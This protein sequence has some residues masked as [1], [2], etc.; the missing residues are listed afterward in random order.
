MFETFKTCAKNVSHQM[1]NKRQNVMS[2]STYEV[3]ILEVLQA[4][5]KSGS[6]S[7]GIE[8]DFDMNCCEPGLSLMK[9]LRTTQK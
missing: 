1:G 3:A 4:S 7:H 6:H 5:L 9:R 8:T 2:I